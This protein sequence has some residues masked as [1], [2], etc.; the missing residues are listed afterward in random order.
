MSEPRAK[1]VEVDGKLVLV[2]PDA[3]GVAKAVG[4]HNCK[5]TLQM[6][7][8]RMVHFAKRVFEKGLKPKDVVIV[9]I[10]IDDRYGELGEVL[11]P[12]VNWQEMRDRGETPYARGLAGREGI[13]SFLDE[14]DED[15]AKKLRE[16][17]GIAIMVADH[18]FTEVFGML[19]IY[20]EKSR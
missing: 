13:Q 3:Y 14:V 10:N 7:K 9:V 6:N 8:D 16:S 11:T 15:S 12:G 5:A 17:D 19:D 4:K 20:E 1:V 2:D 18:Q